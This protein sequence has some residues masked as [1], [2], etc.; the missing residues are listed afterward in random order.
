MLGNFGMYFRE[1]RSPTESEIQLIEDAGRT[2]GIA[3]ERER[4]Q[5]AL[6]AAFEDIKKSA[7]QLRQMVDTSDHCCTGAGW[8]CCVCESDCTITGVSR[9]TI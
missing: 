2:A 4:S 5:T 9:W 8:Q 1:V 3:I 6:K 7:G